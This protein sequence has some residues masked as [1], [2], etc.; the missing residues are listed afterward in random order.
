MGLLDRLFGSGGEKAQEVSAENLGQYLRDME[1]KAEAAPMGT[2]WTFLNRAGDVCLKF[3]DT[4]KAVKYFGQA[5]DALLEDE[6]PEPARGVAKKIIRVHPEAVRTLCTLTWLDLAARQPAAAVLSLGEYSKA[7]VR[8]GREDLASEQV[9][10][11]ARFT[12]DEAFLQEAAEVLKDLGA[13]T[14]A[15]QVREWLEEG[16]SKDSHGEPE[17][18]GRYCLSAAVGSNAL[19]R[20]EGA[21]A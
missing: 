18:L 15:I 11:M 20:A 6:Q 2:G 16:G 7:A 14:Y 9:Y 10:T 1:R 21:V 8:A 4:I 17:A 12:G 3:N 5:I 13:S 19:R